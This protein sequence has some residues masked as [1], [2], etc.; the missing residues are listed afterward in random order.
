MHSPPPLIEA[1]TVVTFS[2][3]SHFW[4]EVVKRTQTLR[5]YLGPWSQA[6]LLI[7]RLELLPDADLEHFNSRLRICGGI[8]RYVFQESKDQSRQAVIEALQ[9]ISAEDLNKIVNGLQ[10]TELSSRLV[11]IVPQRGYLKYTLS[12]ATN[13][14]AEMA[15]KFHSVITSP[16]KLLTYILDEVAFSAENLK[17]SFYEAACRDFLTAEVVVHFRKIER[18]KGRVAALRPRE[19][20][21]LSGLSKVPFLDLDL[22]PARANALYYP[23]NPFFPAIDAFIPG[24]A[25]FQMTVAKRHNLSLKIA[26]IIKRT[27]NNKLF[28]CA[29]R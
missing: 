27:G 10:C 2:P 3:S 5:L 17:G 1:R 12:I 13:Q 21:Q 29:L 20:M 15:L 18:G 24:F 26:S 11:H 16:P 25:M 14:V 8:P 22:L 6:E 7:L 19:T 28:Y 23:S 9:E 4:R